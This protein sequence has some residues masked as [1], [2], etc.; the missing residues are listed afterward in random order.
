MSPHDPIASPFLMKNLSSL[1][2]FLATF[3]SPLT[4]IGQVKSFPFDEPAAKITGE[5]SFAEEGKKGKCATFTGSGAVE[6]T[7]IPFHSDSECTIA[8]WVK[9][10][11]QLRKVIVGSTGDYWNANAKSGGF[12][13]FSVGIEGMAMHTSGNALGI[14]NQVGSGGVILDEE[15][16]HFAY[17]KD[18]QNVRILIDGEQTSAKRLQA[19]MYSTNNK[20]TLFAGGGRAGSPANFSGSIDELHIFAQALPAAAVRAL[21][22]G[23]GPDEIINS[24]I[25][26]F[27]YV[28]YCV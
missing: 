26:Y 8:F 18:G 5:V 7:E 9:G 3:S 21:A 1:I 4:T 27:T 17:V 6:L 13:I 19:E 2:A 12:S 10:K 23:S 22:G 11:E 16:H 20:I 15:W 28:K 25:K 14:N 24:A